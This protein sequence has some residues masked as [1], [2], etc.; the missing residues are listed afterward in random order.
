MSVWKATEEMCKENLPTR[1][2]KCQI[3]FM[4]G[5][6]AVSQKSICCNVAVGKPTKV[7][8]LCKSVSQGT[9]PSKQ[10]VKKQSLFI[11]RNTVTSR[12]QD[13]LLMR[14]SK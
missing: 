13:L 6:S 5:Y 11:V 1:S 10:V 2:S 7:L 3:H 14:I 9:V 4:F 12:I 8:L